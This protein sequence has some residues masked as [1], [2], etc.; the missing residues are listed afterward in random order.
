MVYD[1]LPRKWDLLSVELDGEGL[2]FDVVKLELDLLKL[3]LGGT[4]G[5]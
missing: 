1:G 5:N 2:E 4:K 3:E